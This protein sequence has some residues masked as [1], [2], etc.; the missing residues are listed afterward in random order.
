M[1]VLELGAGM[2][3][4]TAALRDMSK[5]TPGLA[6]REVRAI[7]GAPGIMDLT[8][9]LVGEAD[10]TTALQLDAADWVLSFEVQKTLRMPSDKYGLCISRR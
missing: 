7:D 10:L 8:D 4:Y 6:P 5:K 9:G 1:T 3:C 2:G